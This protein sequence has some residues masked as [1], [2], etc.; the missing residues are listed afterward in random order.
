[1]CDG[2]L[3]EQKGA[4][5]DGERSAAGGSSLKRSKDDGGIAGGSGSGGVQSAG[6]ATID[7]NS[8]KGMQEGAANSGGEGMGGGNGLSGD[9]VD[10]G[11]VDGKVA[12]KTEKRVFVRM[13]CPTLVLA[14][15][16]REAG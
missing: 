9:G 11:G 16:L 4:S 15:L 12:A 6:L 2:W 13:P 14:E 5:K 10:V 8:A 7:S 1:M 3:K